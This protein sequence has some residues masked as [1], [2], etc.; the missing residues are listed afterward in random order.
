MLLLHLNVVKHQLRTIINLIGNNLDFQKQHF[1]SIFNAPKGDDR[2]KNKNTQN[3]T[4]KPILSCDRVG[5]LL[6]SY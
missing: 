4:G 6:Y 3:I 5:F 1:F 2:H